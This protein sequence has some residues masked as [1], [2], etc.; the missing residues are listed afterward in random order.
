MAYITEAQKKTPVTHDVDILICGGGVAGFAAALSAAR[1]GVKVFL[2]EKYGFLGGMAIAALVLTV[3]PLNNGICKEV[4]ERLQKLNTYAPCK[5]PAADP[6]NLGIRMFAYDPEILKHEMA[7][8]LQEE[9]VKLLLHTYIVDAI[10]EDNVIKGIIVQ[11]KG[12][13]QAILAKMVVDATGDADIAYFAKAPYLDAGGEAPMT[14]MFNMVGVDSEKALAQ[15]GNWSNIHELLRQSIDNGDVAFELGLTMRQGAPGVSIENLIYPDEVNIWGGNLFGKSGIKPDELTHAE[16]VTREHAFILAGWLKKNIKGFENSRIEM[17]STQV[18][19]R[20]TRQIQP[21]EL[22]SDGIVCKP[23]SNATAALPYTSLLPQKIGNLVV[24]GRCVFA[25]ED[26]FGG[27]FRLIPGCLATGQ[28][29][30]TAAA[31]ALKKGIMP[32]QL[33]VS[34]LQKTLTEYGMALGL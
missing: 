10:V 8:M 20:K 31:L 1:L 23:Y 34:L 30:G 13:R 25:R 18:G 32:R 12:G 14:M 28:S 24:A 33:D 16:L 19:V 15:I 7:G 6:I 5:Y 22:A 26:E 21:S 29:A 4:A 9:N 17:L 2:V 11:N 27:Q 3:P